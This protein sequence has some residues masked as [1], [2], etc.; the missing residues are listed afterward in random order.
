MAMHSEIPSHL[1]GPIFRAVAKGLHLHEEGGI[2]L[3]ILHNKIDGR[4]H[5]GPKT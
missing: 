1:S 3:L 5:V 4:C 2:P